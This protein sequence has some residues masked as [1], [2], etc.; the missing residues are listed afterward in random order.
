MNETSS[1]NNLH[2]EIDLIQSCITRMANNSFLLKGWFISIAVISFGLLVGDENNYLFAGII[3]AIIAIIFW[4]LDAFFLKMETFYRW[5]YNWVIKVR[6]EGNSNFMYDLNPYNREM[7]QKAKKRKLCLI[8]Y[9]FT[10]T[11]WP[12]YLPVFLSG[13]TITI[14]QNN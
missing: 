3:L 8:R 4:S 11:L 5:K 9:M 12:L 7:W 1:S 2:K 13:V 10:K 6:R 14:L